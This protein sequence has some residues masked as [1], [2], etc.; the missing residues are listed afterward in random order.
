[1]N[2]AIKTLFLL[3]LIICL[4]PTF[5][6]LVAGFIL[7][8]HQ[9]FLLT[10]ILFKRGELV[11]EAMGDSLLVICYFVG[12]YLAVYPIIKMTISVFYENKIYENNLYRILFLLAGIVALV[13]GPYGVLSPHQLPIFSVSTIIFSMLPLIGLIHL[14][15]LANRAHPQESR[16]SGA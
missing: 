11:E 16:E 8:P 15:F 7:L 12:M 10:F 9:I 5:I 4:G 3:E 6:F 1:M 2:K 13:F 14:W